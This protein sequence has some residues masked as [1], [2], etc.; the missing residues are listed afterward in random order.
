MYTT[1][2]QIFLREPR[3]QWRQYGVKMAHFRKSTRPQWVK[4][5]VKMHRNCDSELATGMWTAKR[6]QIKNWSSFF[7]VGWFE[8]FNTIT[9]SLN[10]HK[11]SLINCH[12]R[13]GVVQSLALILDISRSIIIGYYIQYGKDRG[14]TVAEALNSQSTHTPYS[15]KRVGYGRIYQRLKWSWYILREHQMVVIHTA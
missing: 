1:G 14:S 8:F 11:Y 15:P 10:L 2:I 7:Y 9:Y 6:P 4:Q 12:T 13:V 3:L 5:G